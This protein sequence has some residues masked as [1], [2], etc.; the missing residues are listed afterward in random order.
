MMKTFTSFGFV[1]LFLWQTLSA[2]STFNL[3]FYKPDQWGPLAAGSMVKTFDGSFVIAGNFNS[4]NFVFKIDENGDTLWNRKFSAGNDWNDMYQHILEL[5]DSTLFFTGTYRTG[6]NS[7]SNLL[8][9]NLDDQGDPIR[10]WAFSAN[11]DINP[12][13]VCRTVDSGF[14]FTG[15]IYSYRSRNELF[16]M[17]TDGKGN[18]LWAKI[19]TGENINTYGYTVKQ[20]SDSGYIL[21]GAFSDRDNF[22]YSTIFMKLTPEGDVEWA[23]QFG[24]PDS[25]TLIDDV[26]PVENGYLVALGF[27]YDSL[28]IMQTD[29]FGK[30]LWVNKYDVHIN[31]FIYSP[32]LELRKISDGNYMV[33]A[34]DMYSFQDIFMKIDPAGNVLWSRAVQ[35]YLAD[36][37]ETNDKGFLLLGNGPLLLPKLSREGEPQIGINKTDSL[38]ENGSACLGDWMIAFHAATIKRDTMTISMEE[39]DLTAL[40]P[41]LQV[42]SD[43][44]TI[45][46][47]CVEMVGAVNDNED[48]QKITIFP[49]PVSSELNMS[50]TPGHHFTK[51]LIFD[52]F[53]KKVF[54]GLPQPTYEVG[55]L[56]T[57]IYLFVLTDKNGITASKKF[58]KK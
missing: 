33:V 17:K 23:S 43:T 6:K 58:I 53:G 22:A 38:G 44:L 11:G 10:N 25:F 55:H 18:L 29:T 27:Q 37:V 45:R 15:Y 51:A 14:I 21:T 28:I 46:S 39:L 49:N 32:Y 34:T 56:S 2:Q 5:E 40:Q 1:I 26:L 57:G 42:S 7:R 19:M 52:M 20:T 12:R 48:S 50:F 3:V 35:V 9:I 41:E 24:Y 47:G 16:V 13:S 31:S 54:E 4:T 36:V 30:P 8:C